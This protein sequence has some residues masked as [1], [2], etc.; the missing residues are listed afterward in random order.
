MLN[1]KLHLDHVATQ[2]GDRRKSGFTV[3]TQY[4]VEHADVLPDA[5]K[6]AIA[7][8]LVGELQ[9]TGEALFVEAADGTG[10]FDVQGRAGR[11]NEAAIDSRRAPGV[12][13]GH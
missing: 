3:G 8:G 11:K 5:S 13:G 10:S 4:L 2:R 7:A 12:L 6:H 1:V 9:N